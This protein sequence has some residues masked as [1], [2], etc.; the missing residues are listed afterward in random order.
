MQF[1]PYFPKHNGKSNPL[2]PL[3]GAPPPNA[4]IEI[5]ENIKSL[6][7][8]FGGP[9]AGG[10]GFTRAPQN[11]FQLPIIQPQGRSLQWLS[12]GRDG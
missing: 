10:G 12:T 2:R 5:W 6:H 7:V 9:S 8:A 1:C 3:R 11:K 4:T